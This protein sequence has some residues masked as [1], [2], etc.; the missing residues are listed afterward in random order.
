MTKLADNLYDYMSK[1][2][3][4]PLLILVGESHGDYKFATTKYTYIVGCDP[5]YTC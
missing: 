4:F 5:N 2:Q 1:L 3:E